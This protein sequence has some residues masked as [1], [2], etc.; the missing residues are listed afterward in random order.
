MTHLHP[1]K[2]LCQVHSETTSPKRPLNRI[3]KD[4]AFGEKN[5]LKCGRSKWIPSRRNLTHLPNLK[6]SGGKDGQENPEG[7]FLRLPGGMFFP[8][9]AFCLFGSMPNPN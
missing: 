4:L 6:P 1:I 5:K 9:E 8:A 2:S 3:Q 7:A